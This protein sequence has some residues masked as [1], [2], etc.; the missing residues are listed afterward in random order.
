MSDLG[1][2]PLSPKKKDSS[3]STALRRL[4]VLAGHFPQL[5]QPPT[6]GGQHQLSQISVSPTSGGGGGDESR[7]HVELSKRQAE[8]HNAV[9]WPNV[10]ENFTRSGY[11]PSSL[12]HTRKYTGL[13]KLNQAL[14]WVATAANTQGN[15][16][17][18]QATVHSG[19]LVASSNRESGDIAAHVHGALQNPDE[20][21]RTPRE[22]RH[23]ARIHKHLLDK[24]GYAAFRK[25]LV[26]EIGERRG[27]LPRGASWEDAEQQAPGILDAIR[28]GVVGLHQDPKS[29]ALT[30]IPSTESGESSTHAEQ[31]IY[32]DIGTRREEVTGA[33][34]HA[35]GVGSGRPLILP[36][37]GTKR[38]CNVCHEVEHEATREG[39]FSGPFSLLRTSATP[40]LAYDK[41]QYL[42]KS[43]FARPE[44]QAREVV[45]RFQTSPKQLP[46]QAQRHWRLDQAADSDSEDEDG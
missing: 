28:R 27:A 37:A 11:A 3:T 21:A 42:A 41:R 39:L 7:P 40:G 1:P 9:R 33:T 6:T 18:V 31:S 35:L 43:A 2:I 13:E 24:E 34:R 4:R 36:V 29:E 22:K 23:L 8:A 32:E 20:R 5:S 12:R 30:V 44:E 25:K 26:S 45:K 38:P 17:E 10:Y 46:T 16:R 19:G 15:K 14:R